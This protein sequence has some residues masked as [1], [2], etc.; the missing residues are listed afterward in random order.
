MNGRNGA[1][2]ETGPGAHAL[3]MPKACPIIAKQKA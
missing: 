3:I 2:L 1:S